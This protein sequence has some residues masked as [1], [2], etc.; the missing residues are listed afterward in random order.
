MKKDNTDNERVEEG[1]RDGELM[2]GAKVRKEKKEKN[3]GKVK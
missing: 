3:G 2:A 1:R